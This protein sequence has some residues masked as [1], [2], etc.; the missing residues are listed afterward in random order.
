MV[1]PPSAPVAARVDLRA[2]WVGGGAALGGGAVAAAGSIGGR[3]GSVVGRPSAAGRWRRRG[4][5]AGALGRWW[6]G[7]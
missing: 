4:R 6:G 7:P 5:S 2:R 1:E 3:A